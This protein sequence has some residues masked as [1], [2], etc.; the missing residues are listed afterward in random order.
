MIGYY[1]HH[2]GHGHRNRAASIAGAMRTPVTALSSAPLA[3]GVFDRV[4]ELARDDLGEHRDVTAAG[5]VHWAPIRD[6]GM[7]GR[8]AQLAAWVEETDPAALVVDVSVE[9]AVFARLLGVPVIVVAMPGTRDDSPHQLAYGMADAIIAP[10]PSAIYEPGWL[11][12]H[13][14][15][16]TF[17]GGISR[18]AGRTRCVDDA[19]RSDV[20]VMTGSGGTQISE[21]TVE[22]CR[23][24]YPDMTWRFAG[25]PGSWLA[26]PWPAMCNAGVVVGNSG[27]NTVA[28][29]AVAA[30]PAILIP[31][32][33][34]FGEQRAVAEMQRVL[35]LATV[36]SHWPE[37][38]S[39]P[40]LCATAA[41]TPS[42]RWSAW[43]TEGAAERA[44][45]AIEEVA[46][47]WA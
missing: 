30:R 4:I 43:E 35:Q 39:W 9:I 5:M 36:I 40:E 46:Q 19:E 8:M 3:P 15:K 1:V 11:R 24:A 34:P 44:A 47:R 2:Q 32:D 25:G 18:F 33:R 7:R 28:D 38:A 41:Q 23:S 37:L 13:L 42:R 21:Q 20:L 22:A 29:L 27:Q 10:W 12:P 26:D 45:A 14:H 6:P 31:E 16:T 17:T